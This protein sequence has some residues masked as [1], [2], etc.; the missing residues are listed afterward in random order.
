MTRS[1]AI[2]EE[3][4]ARSR[5]WEDAT[6]VARCAVGAGARPGEPRHAG[7]EQRSE[8]EL[9][10]LVIQLGP[11]VASA[12]ELAPMI[13]RPFQAAFAVLLVALPARAKPQHDAV[14]LTY[15]PSRATVALCPAAD[16]LELEVQVRLGYELFQE[17]A[18]N[19]LTVKVDRADG[20]FRF[21][22]ELRDEDGKIIFNEIAS[23]ID[24]TRA[25]LSMAIMVALQF[26][27]PAGDPEAGRL[28]PLPPAPSCPP[29]PLPVL[30]APAPVV[31]PIE[32]PRFQAGLA[33]VFAIGKAP[34]LLGGAGWFVGVRWHDFSAALEG[35]ALFA[36]SADVEGIPWRYSFA[37]ASAAICMHDAW[38]LVCVRGEV[39][40][41]QGKSHTGQTYPRHAPSVGVAM[42]IARDWTITPALVVRPYLE[43][44][45]E[46][47]SGRIISTEPVA[48]LWVSPSLSVSLGLG[49]VMSRVRLSQE[50]SN[51]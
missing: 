32:L 2:R 43:I 7:G 51:E 19:H 40:S 6:R 29:P 1:S 48:P 31:T 3:L 49:L 33:S 37:A 17:A 26:T 4:D 21:A 23:G 42:R 38:G 8:I 22:G 39:G 12:P 11:G 50:K 44:M 24:C 18:P 25:L 34:V 30:P 46:T 27:K 14:T 36:P 16:L 28:A 13:L 9:R 20:I 47:A 10:G 45:A 15:L 41:L 35:R 5:C